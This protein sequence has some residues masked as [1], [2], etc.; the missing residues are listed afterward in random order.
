MSEIVSEQHLQMLDEFEEARRRDTTS[1][2]MTRTLDLVHC[3]SSCQSS[4]ACL[5]V[6]SPR[7][8]PW[9]K[10]TE[11]P[12]KCKHPFTQTFLH[13]AETMR[14]EEEALKTIKLQ[15]GGEDG[16]AARVHLLIMLSHLRHVK[17][18]SCL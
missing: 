7:Y 14:E 9:L 2:L 16:R 17:Q 8:T 18:V 3:T 10:I 12:P 6:R 1:S 13:A 4:D 11:A 5:T 15:L